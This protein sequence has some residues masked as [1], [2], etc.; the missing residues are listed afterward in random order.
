MI[1]FDFILYWLLN[2][3]HW[4]NKNTFVK[5]LKMQT[6]VETV[7]VVEATETCCGGSTTCCREQKIRDRAYQLWQEA[8][9]PYCDGS[10]FWFE[11]EAEVAAQW[12]ADLTAGNFTE[13]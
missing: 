12:A 9:E 8:G 4:F 5:G 11:A 3:L 2:Q 10:E 7:D 6:L 1:Y 13:Q